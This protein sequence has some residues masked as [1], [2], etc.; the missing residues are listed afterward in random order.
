M[1]AEAGGPLRG[2]HRMGALRLV[3]TAAR[4][5]VCQLPVVRSCRPFESVKHG[6]V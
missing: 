1:R 5:V 3:V 4:G 2:S 6:S